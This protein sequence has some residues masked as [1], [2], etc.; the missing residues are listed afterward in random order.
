MYA[1]VNQV[2]IGSDNGLSPIRR[3]AIISTNTGLLS[4]GP[5]RTTFSE[6]FIKIQNFSF[7]KMH[8]KISPAKW[9]PFCPGGDELTHQ[10]W[11]TCIIIISKQGHHWFRWW[12]ITCLAPS[13]YLTQCC[14][15]SIRLLKNKLQWNLNKDSDIFIIK[16]MCLKMYARRWP[17]CLAPNECVNLSLS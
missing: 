5:L 7:G 15:F 8:M 11:V 12:L 17:I 1:S 2:S 13:H 10:G 6:I 4:T 9:R 14:L 16:N 3:Q